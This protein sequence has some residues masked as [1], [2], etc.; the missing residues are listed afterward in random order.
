MKASE[1]KQA[2]QITGVVFSASGLRSQQQS[3]L[4]WVYTMHM[5][6][7]DYYEQGLSTLA[8]RFDGHESFEL[9]EN[10]DLGILSQRFYD[11][12]Y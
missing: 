3:P 5:F 7:S 10:L 9:G 11:D 2:R 4:V 1:L 8:S 12:I 6:I